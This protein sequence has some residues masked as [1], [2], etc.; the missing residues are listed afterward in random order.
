MGTTKKGRA[1]E[2]SQRRGSLRKRD[3]SLEKAMRAEAA[4]E[5]K[6][7]ALPEYVPIGGPPRVFSLCVA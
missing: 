3:R 2:S 4:V 7:V 1:A 5:R 6:T